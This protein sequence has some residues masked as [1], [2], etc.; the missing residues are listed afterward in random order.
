MIVVSVTSW[1]AVTPGHTVEGYVHEDVDGD[2]DVLDDG[3]GLGNVVVRLYRDGGDDTPDGVDDVFVKSAV[4]DSGGQYTLAD[5]SDAIYWVV[6]DSRTIVASAGCQA[7]RPSAT[8]EPA[9]EDVAVLMVG[10]GL[11]GCQDGCHAKKSYRQKGSSLAVPFSYIFVRGRS[12][13]RSPV[14]CD[15]GATRDG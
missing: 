2:G 12:V 9:R 11:C 4:T 15:P 6:V 3:V 8:E 13:S 5:L 7:V 14:R 10:F 1:V